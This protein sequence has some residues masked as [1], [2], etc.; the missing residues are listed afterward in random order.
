MAKMNYE[1]VYAS[2]GFSGE[3]WDLVKGY[4]L[5][6]TSPATDTT[7]SIAGTITLA[8]GTFPAWMQVPGTVFTTDDG[9]N[10]GPF[11]VLSATPS[12]V[13]VNEAVAASAG[14]TTVFTKGSGL[15]A[16]TL[17][18]DVLLNVGDGT[19]TDDAPWMLTSTGAL[20]AARELILDN[21]EVESAAKGGQPLNGR[22][23]ILSV[24][25][26]DILTNALTVTGST[27]VNGSAG[28]IVISTEGDYLFQ[29]VQGGV[30]RANILP[31]PSESL[32]TIARIPFI[33]AD[34]DAGAVKNTIVV[35]RIAPIA[36][37]QVGPHLLTAAGSYVVQVINTDLTPDEQVDVEIQFAAS[38]D[39]TLKKA[40]KAPDF[41]GVVV[42]L[43][44]L[45]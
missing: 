20:G 5:E 17:I 28:G 8:T 10:P 42:I 41:N 38:G 37:G 26:S 14:V 12:V 23:F 9:G 34:W 39:I 6:Y 33:A 19:L 18:Q 43:G 45:D 25:N 4:N 3:C 30:W 35:K 22:I 13:T 7:F 27:S 16:D 11:T 44:S 40:A 32:A 2:A 15:G 24:Q 36:A 21:T 31:R 29:H 1:H